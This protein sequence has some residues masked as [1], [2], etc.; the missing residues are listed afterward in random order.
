MTATTFASFSDCIAG[1]HI[2]AL[3]FAFAGR[4]TFGPGGPQVIYI[5]VAHN[6]KWIPDMFRDS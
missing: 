3:V 2:L 6:K 1:A 4:V 5:Y